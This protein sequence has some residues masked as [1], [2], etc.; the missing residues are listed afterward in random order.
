MHVM[1]NNENTW[2][3]SIVCVHYN[4][5]LPSLRMTRG[6]CNALQDNEKGKSTAV[7]T[8]LEIQVYS[9]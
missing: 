3:I 9:K 2:V 7:N 4:L 1:F 5:M 6:K 8:G